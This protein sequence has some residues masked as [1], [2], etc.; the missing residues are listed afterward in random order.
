M[1]PDYALGLWQSKMRYQTQDEV[2]EVARR[3]K[4]KGIT[5][6]VIVIDFFHW[7]EQGHFDFDERYWPDPAKMIKELD[8]MGIKAMISVWPTVS[9]NAKTYQEFLENGYLKLL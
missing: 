5:L 7:T 9:T 3:Y 1:M 4:E 2:M 8:E 6:S